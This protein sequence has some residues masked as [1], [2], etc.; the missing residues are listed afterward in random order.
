[1]APEAASEAEQ[2]RCNLIDLCKHIRDMTKVGTKTIPDPPHRFNLL[3]RPHAPES[4]CRICSLP[5]HH[6]VSVSD[7]AGCR[8]ALLSLIGFWED[9]AEN[10]K[11][12]YLKSATFSKKIAASKPTY[13]MRLST[14][15]PHGGDMEKVIVEG[16]TR[17][18]LRFQA[19]V[20]SLGEKVKEVLTET[21]AK[22]YEAVSGTLNEFLLHSQTRKF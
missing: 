2:V 22:R 5:G 11:F 1:M 16:L 18:Y 10:I 17:S 6:S 19:L 15:P 12:L 13:A 3:A 14:S 8:A 9:R 20:G 7:S 4:L 21:D